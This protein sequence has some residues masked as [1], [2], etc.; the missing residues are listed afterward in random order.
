[1]EQIQAFHLSGSI[2]EMQFLVK[3]WIQIFTSVCHYLLLFPIEFTIIFF[4]IIFVF[5]IEFA[6]AFFAIIFVFFY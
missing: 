4:A 2:F 6:I 1:M 5:S 3:I